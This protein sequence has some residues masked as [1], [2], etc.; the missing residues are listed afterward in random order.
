MLPDIE[1]LLILQS[2]DQ[3]IAELE[4]DLKR[5]PA[6]KDLART[7]LSSSQTAVDLAKAAMQ[8]NEMAIKTVELDIETRKTT[9][10]RLKTQQFETRKNEEFRALNTEVEKYQAQIDELETTELELM[11]G[12]DELRLKLK[13]ARELLA[14]AEASVEEDLQ[15]YDQRE[16]EERD[17]LAELREQRTKS[18]AAISDEDALELYDRLRKA[19]GT[20]VVVNLSPSGQC[21]GCHVK[22]T[23]STLIKVQSDKEMVQCEN[24]G[25]ILYAG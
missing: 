11:E 5:I 25:R 22:V 4:T 8:E 7:R 3:S 24:C 21:D 2:R 18:E 15:A 20:K 23:P 9:I 19:R 6:E 1:R 13:A 12:G 16:K 10:G 14:K 17:R